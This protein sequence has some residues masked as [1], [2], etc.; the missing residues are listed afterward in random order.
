MYNEQRVIFTEYKKGSSLFT[1]RKWKQRSDPKKVVESKFAVKREKSIFEKI[2]DK[3]IPA[4]IL[5]EDEKC[6][7]IKDVNPVAK[8]HFLVVP[9]VKI[10]VLIDVK[11]KHADIMGHL[12]VVA[13]KVAS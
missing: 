8:I 7:A 2:I 1:V 12:L 11:D 5:F 13:A 10:A 9:K 4:D 6:I 3:E